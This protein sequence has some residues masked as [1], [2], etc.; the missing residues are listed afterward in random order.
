MMLPPRTLQEE[1]GTTA[2]S[3]T[4]GDGKR[5]RPRPA[6]SCLQCRL[7]KLKCNRGH[8]CDRCIKRFKSDPSVA[9]E[10]TYRQDASLGEVDATGEGNVT[11]VDVNIEEQEVERGQMFGLIRPERERPAKM[12]R[13]ESR[14]FG[15][16]P[17]PEEEQPRLGVI[18]DLQARLE[19]VEK[20][21]SA[22]KEAGHVLPARPASNREGM[23]RA[24]GDSSCYHPV[25]NRM[26]FIKHVRVCPDPY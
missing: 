23:L 7:K 2:I 11:V 21:L 19:K 17:A 4:G 18:E 3:E 26:S 20:M 22:H 6:F 10:C 14:N 1:N 24:K 13:L 9:Q 5:K 16:R 25:G 8:P 12:A 15:D